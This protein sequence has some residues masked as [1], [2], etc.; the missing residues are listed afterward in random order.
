MKL[1]KYSIKFADHVNSLCSNSKNMR[2]NNRY[3]MCKVVFSGREGGLMKLEEEYI[4]MLA[5]FVFI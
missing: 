2:E 3:P 5:V 1:G 4:G